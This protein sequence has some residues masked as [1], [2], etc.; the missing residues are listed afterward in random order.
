MQR[1]SF[2]RRLQFA[3]ALALGVSGIALA[4]DSSMSRLTGDSYAY[5][6]G[7]D[8][9]PGAFSV[10]TPAALAA[11]SKDR[12]PAAR[13]ATAPDAPTAT[14]GPPE[15]APVREPKIM[16]AAPRIVIAPP[17]TFRDD[18]A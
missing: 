10:A 13:A 2:T 17:A 16:L 18:T 8:Y 4:D 6:N 12:A 1:N 3:A 5:F 11:G 9:R 15:D 7:L 14:V